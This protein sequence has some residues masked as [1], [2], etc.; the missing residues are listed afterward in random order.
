MAW[1][2]VL[3]PVEREFCVGSSPATPTNNLSWSNGYDVGFWPSTQSIKSSF[4]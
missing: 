1:R 4:M 2:W 3:T